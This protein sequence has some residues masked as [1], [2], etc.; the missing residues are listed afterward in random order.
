MT[1][2]MADR[3]CAYRKKMGL[4]QEELAE[5][6]GVSRQAV[7][8]WERAEASPDTDNLILLAQ[9]Y[10]V[11]LDEL[12]KAN[13]TEETLEETQEDGVSFQNGIHVR[14][15]DGDEVHIAFSGVHVDTAKGE[16]V[17]VGFDGVRVEDRNHIFVEKEKT[18]FEKA[19]NKIPWPLFCVAAYLL[20]GF[21]G[22]CGGWSLGWLVFLTIPLYYSLGEAIGKKDASHFAYPVLVTLVYLVMGFWMKLWHPGWVVFVTIPAYYCICAPFKKEPEE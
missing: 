20:M 14:S 19:W 5:K 22:W 9:V 17:H 6:I 12:L 16:H 21:F 2:E 15:K 7:S 13:P 11:T 18:K 4:S 1:I 8:K 3:L 10:G